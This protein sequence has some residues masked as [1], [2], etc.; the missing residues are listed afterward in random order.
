MLLIHLLKILFCLLIT[1]HIIRW[2]SYHI[3]HRNKKAR[4]FHGNTRM[5]FHVEFALMYGVNAL[6]KIRFK[7]KDLSYRKS[8]EEWRQLLNTIYPPD[9]L[10]ITH[11][12]HPNITGDLGVTNGNRKQKRFPFLFPQFQIEKNNFTPI[13][14]A[15]NAITEKYMVENDRGV[16]S[17]S[18]CSKI[19]QITN[20]KISKNA[21]SLSK[22]TFA[23][24]RQIFTG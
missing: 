7:I 16:S 21:I 19:I 8:L 15:Y 22:Q 11:Q 12:S 20:L 13:K 4:V 3:H 9:N 18:P 5:P 14:K 24:T 6:T 10:T 17:A 2:V 23:C 1:R